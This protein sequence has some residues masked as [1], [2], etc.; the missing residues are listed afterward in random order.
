MTK[1]NVL[2]KIFSIEKVLS[3]NWKSNENFSLFTGIGGLPLFYVML[4][5]LT[6]E[7]KYLR[8]NQEIVEELFER[9]NNE[10][11][12]MTYT[13]GITGLAYLFHFLNDKGFLEEDISETLYFLDDVILK[14]TKKQ[15]KSYADIDFLH[16]GLGA[17]NYLLL[18]TNFNSAIE[19]ETI[20]IF[21]KIARLVEEDISKT[22][23]VKN[24]S[25]YDEDSHRTNCGLA[26]G[27]ISN[28][29]IF[30]KFLS[31]YKDNTLIKRILEKSV[32][33]VLSFKSV[34]DTTLAAFPSIAVSKTTAS[35]RIPLGWCYGDQ[36]ISLGLYRAA[37]VLSSENLYREALSNARRTLRRDDFIKAFMSPLSDAG[38]CHGASS[39]AYLHKKWFE[40]T[41]EKEFDVLYEKFIQEIMQKGNDNLGLAGYRKF[42]GHNDYE[43]SIGLLDGVIGIGIVL[44]DYILEDENSL[45]W[46][47]FFLLN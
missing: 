31:K 4:F 19:S 46:D 5:K 32:E 9:L 26:H 44:I 11:Y 40:I 13:S 38:F 2:E 7:K 43:N 37:K 15:L 28:I 10:N 27:H 16:G 12:N 23:L 8:K 39:L 17:A 29:I 6:K 3:T 34:D 1:S 21:E 45:S 35:Y 47:E 36:T 41:K 33:C 42:I 14:F 18:R 30:S 22:M 24:V 20:V 25:T